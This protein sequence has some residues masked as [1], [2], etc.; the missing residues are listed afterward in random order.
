MATE[1]KTITLPVLDESEL[2][3]GEM[4]QV[5]FGEGESKGKVLLVK[6]DGKV[7]R[8]LNAKDINSKSTMLNIVLP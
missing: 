6:I 7:V 4:K 8:S 2:G 1:A 5:E 3:N